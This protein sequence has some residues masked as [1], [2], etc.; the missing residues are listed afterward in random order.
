MKK[1]L[2]LFAIL[3]LWSCSDRSSEITITGNGKT[4]AGQTIYLK[5]Y[6]HFD[7][8]EEYMID[9]TVVEPDGTFTFSL[10]VDEPELVTIGKSNY[11]PATYMVLRENP[12]HYYYSFCEKFFGFDP[13][14]Y[15]EQGTNY[16]ITHWNKEE[17]EVTYGDAR[18]NLLR[19]YYKD[20]DWKKDLRDPNRDP[21]QMDPE[22][23]WKIVSAQRDGILAELDFAGELENESFENYLKTEIEL[24][25][26]NEY[27]LWNY[28]QSENPLEG[29]QLDQIMETYNAGDWNPNSV[30]LYKLTERYISHRMNKQK[31]KNMYY[32]E[33]GAKKIAMAEK[34]ADPGIREKFIRNMKILMER[35]EG[36]VVAKAQLKSILLFLTTQFSS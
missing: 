7:Y 5:K 17:D 25:A 2:P 23:A 24:G 31:G 26:I 19:K 29:E 35:N 10:K 28:H 8:M 32:Y 27:L 16:N 18:H 22:K 4:L 14:F 30:E 36:E 9:S 6:S 15:V 3:F 34:Y 12:D 11:P 33:P 13:L 21:L 1:L 20:I